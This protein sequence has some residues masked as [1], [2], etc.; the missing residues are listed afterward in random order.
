MHHS[1]FQE[2]EKECP[3]G[4]VISSIIWHIISLVYGYLGNLFLDLM[5]ASSA[6]TNTTG[7]R[8]MT[9]VILHN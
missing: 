7:L 8:V 2:S 9:V 1:H 5:P 4:V 6:I 3:K